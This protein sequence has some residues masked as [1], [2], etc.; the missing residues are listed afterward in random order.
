MDK[1]IKTEECYEEKAEKGKGTSISVS[2]FHPWLFLETL[3]LTNTKLATSSVKHETTCFIPMNHY[4][5]VPYAYVFSFAY[6]YRSSAS[7]SSLYLISS[8]FYITW[9]TFILL[10]ISNWHFKI[11]GAEISWANK[12]V[13]SPV[14]FAQLASSI[15]WFPNW[16]ELNKLFTS[17][18]IIFNWYT[19]IGNVG[20]YSDDKS[21]SSNCLS[22][23]GRMRLV[24]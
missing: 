5:Y 8:P 10:S 7:L 17:K 20:I 6:F 18:T 9:V 14:W 24:L 2:S 21:L 12:P 1:S 3:S 15:S 4:K 16:I 13:P 11:E 19:K 22:F 23:P